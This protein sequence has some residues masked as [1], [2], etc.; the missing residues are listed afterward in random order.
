MRSYSGFHSLPLELLLQ[1]TFHLP[2]IPIPFYQDDTLIELDHPD[3]PDL[4]TLPE[5]EE[6]FTTL[7]SLSQTSRNLRKI[8]LPLAWQ[9]IDVLAGISPLITG[10]GLKRL[11]QSN[12]ALSENDI[13]TRTVNLVI[14]GCSEDN[15]GLL[16]DFLASLPNL[17]NVQILYADEEMSWNDDL[18]IQLN[19]RSVTIPNVVSLT[20]PNPAHQFLPCFPN[21]KALYVNNAPWDPNE[22]RFGNI[23]ATVRSSCKHVQV[24]DTCSPIVDVE[25]DDSDLD[26]DI[27]DSEMERGI[28]ERIVEAMPNL[29]QFPAIEAH[30]ILRTDSISLLS[31][32]KKLRCIKFAG[33]TSSDISVADRYIDVA[34]Q[35][36]T[37]L[38]NNTEDSASVY[39][40]DV[41]VAT[42][43]SS[44]RD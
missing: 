29:V 4:V 32:L 26:S 28:I 31:N 9:S 33:S 8:F 34:K 42:L 44:V 38:I 25:V 12:D 39:L 20:I 17:A 43:Q 37:G 14:Q 2:P 40:D 19:K 21:L 35:V 7:R 18:K 13:Y 15:L 6:R 1:V 5:L 30:E 10:L 27:S 11:I 16:V 36:L 23:V 3:R 41:L 24:F 22:E